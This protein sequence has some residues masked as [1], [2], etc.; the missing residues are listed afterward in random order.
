[1]RPRSAEPQPPSRVRL[2]RPALYRSGDTGVL[3]PDVRDFLIG[4]TTLA[5]DEGWLMWRPAELGAALYP[6]TQP[7][8]RR[9]DLERRA[10]ILVAA[11]LLVL[12]DCGCAFL[13][14]LKR[15]HAVKSGNPTTA[16]WAWHMSHP[17]A[18]SVPVRTDP[19]ESRSDSDSSSASASSS[20]KDSDSSSAS[21]RVRAV[22]PPRLME[23]LDRRA[24]ANDPGRPDDLDD[25]L[26]A[27][28]E[29]YLDGKAI[30]E[31]LLLTYV[32][33]LTPGGVSVT[34]GF[35]LRGALDLAQRAS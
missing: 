5:D 25:E 8:R 19:S 13:P 12:H 30:R 21:S 14:T 10:A 3:P 16:V 4:L 15:D 1:M 23:A 20:L 26:V 29:Q 24:P 22:L 33:S 17:R 2:V 28:A 27:R 6:Y 18:E 35:L 34:R 9:R 7:K 31:E 32:S 11:D